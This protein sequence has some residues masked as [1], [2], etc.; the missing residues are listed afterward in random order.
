M[1]SVVVDGLE[2]HRVAR[3]TGRLDEDIV[4]LARRDEQRV[5]LVRLREQP[6]VP[7]DDE[8]PGAPEAQVEVAAVGRVH[9]APPLAPARFH[10]EGG[11]GTAVDE[12]DVALTA[13]HD[14]E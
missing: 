12:Q 2:V 4:A 6:S 13:Q 1:A 3:A 9:E 10:G 11:T 8:E 5:H 14:V 7:S